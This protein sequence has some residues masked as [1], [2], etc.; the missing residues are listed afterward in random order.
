M[1]C[2]TFRSKQWQSCARIVSYYKNR[3]L[4]QPTT[5]TP[6]SVICKLA[7]VTFSLYRVP[8]GTWRITA[9][10][11]VWTAPDGIKRARMRSL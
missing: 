3:R 1:S 4:R 2:F 10:L 8:T 9:V 5:H 7:D 11:L 6:G